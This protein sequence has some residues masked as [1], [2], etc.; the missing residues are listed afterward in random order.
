MKLRTS[1]NIW[2]FT[3]ISLACAVF[4]SIVQLNTNLESSRAEAGRSKALTAI[5]QHVMSDTC[6]QLSG[7]DLIQ[8]G[9]LVEEVGGKTPTS[10]Y[11]TE[12]QY[13]HVVY[14]GGRLQVANVFS[15]KEVQSRISE[16]SNVKDSNR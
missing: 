13:A 16:V 1:K 8:K 11:Q 10:C 15:K 9:E 4:G 7:A 6:R 2:G 14:L 5:A 3:T 12:T